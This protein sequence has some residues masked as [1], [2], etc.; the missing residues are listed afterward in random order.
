MLMLRGNSAPAGKYPDERGKNIAWPVGALHVS[1]ASEYAKRRGYDAVV[2]DVGGQPQSQV[3]PQAKAALKAFFD[4]QAVCAFYGFSGGGYNLRHILDYLASNRPD[5]LHRISLLV[6]LGAPL[7]GKPAYEASKYN[8]V[9]SKKAG[10]AT[11]QDASWEVVY[12]T[13]P[14]EKWAKRKGVSVGGRHMFGPEWLLEG[15]PAA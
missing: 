6:V 4:D 7:Q 10:S 11:W 14:P 8:T 12:G 2:L 1:A 5:A 9:A 15:M 13:D 3:S